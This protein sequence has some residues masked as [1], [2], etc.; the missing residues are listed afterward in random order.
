MKRVL[1]GLAIVALSLAVSMNAAR[2]GNKNVLDIISASL[3]GTSVILKV[4]NTTKDLVTGRA[5]GKANN[6][7]TV[8]EDLENLVRLEPGVHTITLDFPEKGSV[9]LHGIQDGPD[10][11]NPGVRPKPGFIIVGTIT[12]DINPF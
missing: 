12:D 3:E 11:F 2:A 1:A 9:E 7:T 10:P 5:L 8:Q 6:G 4:E